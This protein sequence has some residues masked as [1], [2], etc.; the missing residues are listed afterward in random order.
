MKKISA[1]VVINDEEKQLYDC[2]QTL[3]F[4]DEIVV[5]LDKCTDNSEKIARKFTDKI[6]KGSW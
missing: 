6:F 2:L 3:K 4:S 5:I 1:L